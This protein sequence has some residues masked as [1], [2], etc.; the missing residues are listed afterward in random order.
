[1]RVETRLRRTG[2]LSKFA[3]LI[4]VPVQTRIFRRRQIVQPWA[5]E[6]QSRHCF[7]IAPR[8]CF[9]CGSLQKRVYHLPR[10]RLLR[11][12]SQ[13]LRVSRRFHRWRVA[14]LWLDLSHVALAIGSQLSLIRFIDADE[15]AA[16]PSVCGPNEKCW[17]VKGSYMCCQANKSFDECQAGTNLVLIWSVFKTKSISARLFICSRRVWYTMRSELG[18]PRS[19]MSV[20]AG[21]CAGQRRA[22][23]G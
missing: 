21:I 9:S 7:D 17:N 4:P 11:P 3:R 20:Q 13:H 6:S 23:L 10:G 18:M 22:L 19:K 14:V 16:S 5:H 8:T 15:C 2:G 12:G 1:V